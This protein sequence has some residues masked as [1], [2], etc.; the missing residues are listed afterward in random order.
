V[1]K[2]K[3][4]KQLLPQISV[5]PVTVSDKPRFFETRIDPN[6]LPNDIRVVYES[7][8]SLNKE[9][10]ALQ[11][12][13]SVAANDKSTTAKVRADIK[14]ELDTKIAQRNNNYQII[15]EWYNNKDKEPAPVTSDPAQLV[16]DIKAAEKF[17]QRNKDSKDPLVIEKFNQRLQFLKNNGITWP[18]S[19]KK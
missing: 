1:E 15:D 18:P 10:S 16:K 6:T 13:L 11:A 14:K 7:N 3:D 4:T 2:P 17:L 9:I 5:Q 8:K 19:K 12:H